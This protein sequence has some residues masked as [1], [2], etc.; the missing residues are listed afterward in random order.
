METIELNEFMPLPFGENP[1]QV[2]VMAK[3][4]DGIDYEILSQN[5][6]IEYIDYLNLSE[7]IKICA[8]FFDVDCAVITN[9]SHI[10]S[11]AL[12]A[13]LHNAFEKSLDCDPVSS[14][15]ATVAFSKE[16]DLELAK[17]I[18]SIKFRNI[19]APNFSKNAI[20]YLTDKDI[21]VVK[22]N[23]PLQELLG[24]TTKDI[25]IT[26]FGALI[27]EQ[28]RAKLTKDNFKV[29][30]KTKPS[31]QQAE[32][33]IFAW[34][35]S[36]HLKSRS[37]IIAKDLATKAIIQARPNSIVT[38]EIALDY[39]CEATKDAVLALDGVIESPQIINSA[40]QARIGL[41]IDSND[42][43]NSSE[44]TKLAD[45]YSISIISTGIRNNKY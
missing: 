20:D 32:D 38:T 9:E 7:A 30:T 13:N 22:L 12:G 27:Q 43:M 1:N 40:I 35:I 14:Y 24:F 39:A 18:V 41:I 19:I 37:A 44:I 11:V 3:I 15:N 28:N 2:A 10:C 36:K 29:A 23:S 16:V 17:Q 8:E 45:K 31:Q 33:A 34:K 21:N 4:D 6:E 26:P 25:K 5:K 42:G